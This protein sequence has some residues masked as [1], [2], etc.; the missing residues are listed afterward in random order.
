[1]LLVA[2]GVSLFVLFGPGGAKRGAPRDNTDSLTGNSVEPAALNGIDISVTDELAWEASDGIRP[3]GDDETIAIAALD[4]E[5]VPEPVPICLHED[6]L[7]MPTLAS[8]ETVGETLTAMGIALNDADYVFP[9][10]GTPLSAGAHIYVYHARPIELTVGGETA[11]VYTRARTVEETLAQEDVRLGLLDRVDPS[12]ETPIEERLAI[13][14]TQVREETVTIEEPIPLSIV[15]QDDPEMF[16]GQYKVL[17]WGEDGLVHREYRMVYEDGQE[18]EREL[19]SEWEQ[20]ARDQ[21]IAQGTKVANIV[22]TPSG[23][24][25]YSQALDVYTT[26]Y[27]PASA[28]RSPDSPWYGISATGVAVHRGIVA[29]DPNVIP[30]GTRLYIPGYGE[31]VAAD[32]GSGVI[33]YHVDVGFA[34]YEVPDWRSGWATVYILEP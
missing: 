18:V 6:G 7:T 14:V 9:S 1:M 33:G 16:V 2:G 34:D 28:G 11:T 4:I 3:D 21:L 30:L 5:R 12:L 25:R 17:D 22:E 10:R 15:Y 23:P 32:T 13:R 26:W 19:V 24:L 27:N 29:V 8:A 20:P 31:A